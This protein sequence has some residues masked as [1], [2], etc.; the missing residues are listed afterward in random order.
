[1]LQPKAISVKPLQNYLLELVFD[2][3]ERKIFDV[4]PYLVGSW[5]SKLKDMN[6]FN[7]VHIAGLSIEWA[8]GQDISP[9]EL[10]DNS[11]SVLKISDKERSF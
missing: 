9:H 11:H 4:K 6:Y 3:G 10:Y 1:M 2:N 5:F 7:T 8:D